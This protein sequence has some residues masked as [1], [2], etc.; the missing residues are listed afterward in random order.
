MNGPR[1][2][3]VTLSAAIGT[4]FLRGFR[5]HKTTREQEGKTAAAPEAPESGDSGSGATPTTS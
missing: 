4:A 2:S 5:D 3:D 1:R